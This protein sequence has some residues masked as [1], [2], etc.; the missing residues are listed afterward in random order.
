VQPNLHLFLESINEFRILFFMT[1]IYQL[2]AI[3]DAA[4]FAAQK[5]QGH[6][7]KD[8]RASPYI[9]HPLAVARAINKIGKI[10]DP[11]LLIAAI[12]HDTIEDTNTTEAEIQERFGKEILSIVLEVTDDKSQNKMARKQQQ[13]IHAPDLTRGAKIIKLADKLTN[14]LDI[15]HTP[16][17]DWSLNRRQEYIQWAADVVAQIRGTN[18]PLEAAFDEM[19]SQAEKSLDYRLEPFETV[20]N[21]PWGPNSD[22][23]SP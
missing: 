15:L 18:P 9:T 13:V 21:R 16:P 19:L 2:D 20:N 12:L 8:E 3:L 17:K 5:H 23:A 1:D 6:I 14:C 11:T 22:T 7:R 10:N 4:I